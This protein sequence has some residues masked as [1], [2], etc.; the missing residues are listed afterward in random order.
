MG[1][2][3]LSEISIGNSLSPRLREVLKCISPLRQKCYISMLT[4]YEQ[5]I[6][7]S[8]RG[9]R[10]TWRSKG[11]SPSEKL[12]IVIT[13]TLHWKY[14]RMLIIWTTGTIRCNTRVNEPDVL[15][16]ADIS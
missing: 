16:P 3:A 2:I 5:E 14:S 12:K 10:N 6:R 4:K 7:D 1:Y 11:I 13:F 9:W 15:R 8:A